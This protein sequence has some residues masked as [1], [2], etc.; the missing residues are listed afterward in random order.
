MSRISLEEQQGVTSALK[1]LAE[2]RF[3]RFKN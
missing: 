1:K 2:R 3:K